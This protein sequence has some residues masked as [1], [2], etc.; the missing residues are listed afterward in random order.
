MLLT[1]QQVSFLKHFLKDY[2]SVMKCCVCFV[3][4]FFFFFFFFFFQYTYTYT[5]VLTLTTN[6]IK[7]KTVEQ[8]ILDTSIN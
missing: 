4:F 6:K 2:V 7:C 3:L 1:V 8:E 5:T